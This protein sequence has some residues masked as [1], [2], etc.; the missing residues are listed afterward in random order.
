MESKPP[1]KSFGL[2][3]RMNRHLRYSKCHNTELLQGN[4][5]QPSDSPSLPVLPDKQKRNVPVSLH[6]TDS[7]ELL[8]FH[9]SEHNQLSALHLRHKILI[10]NKFLKFFYTFPRIRRCN[11][12][13]KHIPYQMQSFQYFLIF[14]SFNYHTLYLFMLFLLLS[15]RQQFLPQKCKRPHNRI[16]PIFLPVSGE[17]FRTTPRKRK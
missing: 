3:R 12:S 14:Q 7:A 15:C 4:K 5:E 10:F 2:R 8:S 16:I 11:I 1:V 6:S 13:S 17:R 9:C